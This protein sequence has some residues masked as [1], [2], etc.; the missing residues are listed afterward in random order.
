MRQKVC[1]DTLDIWLLKFNLKKK[2]KKPH[3]L[4]CFPLC[5][6]SFSLICQKSVSYILLLLLK[7]S[8]YDLQFC[9]LCPCGIGFFSKK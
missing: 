9:F 2:K 3:L 7:Y 8:P 4:L 6:V 1:K 5:S